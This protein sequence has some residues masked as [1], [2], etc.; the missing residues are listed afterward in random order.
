MRPID[1]VD[2]HADER[3]KALIAHYQR[4]QAAPSG[5]PRRI[6]IG[7]GVPVFQ[8]GIYHF[9][10]NQRGDGFL[11]ILKGIGRFLFPVAAS[12]VG[13]FL[14]STADAKINTD[15]SWKEA[16]KGA[17]KPAFAKALE[18]GRAH[19]DKLSERHTRAKE[20]ERNRVSRMDQALSQEVR[21]QIQA[22]SPAGAMTV[23]QPG[24]AP[25]IMRGTTEEAMYRPPPSYLSAVSGPYYY[26]MAMHSQM[27]PN[28]SPY[29]Y[30]KNS[31]YDYQ[32]RQV[33]P[34]AVAPV[35]STESPEVRGAGRRA[36]RPMVYKRKH[37]GGKRSKRSVKKART[38]PLITNF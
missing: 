26:P 27:R 21:G 12:A 35:S 3:V 6:Q 18:T 19:Y 36:L 5:L 25:P 4:C 31:M 2:A 15:T 16:A 32:G 13:Q 11:D 28:F 17:L 7:R 10:P 1:I 8:G 9:D 33:P 22:S 37:K 24:L 34:E 38:L 29:D 23:S 14:G 30:V 20:D